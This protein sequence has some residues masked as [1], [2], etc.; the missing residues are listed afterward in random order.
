MTITELNHSLWF[1]IAILAISCI[2]L[3]GAIIGFAAVLAQ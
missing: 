1:N 3:T 2:G